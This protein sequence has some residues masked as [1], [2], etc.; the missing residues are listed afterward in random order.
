MVRPGD[1]VAFSLSPQRNMA[2]VFITLL[3][4]LCKYRYSFNDQ[5]PSI[6]YISA[7]GC[8]TDSEL[9]DFK[10]AFVKELTT[11]D[12]F[13]G[14]KLDGECDILVIDSI[15]MISWLCTDENELKIYQEKINDLTR[16][17]TTFGMIAFY[18]IAPNTTI[19]LNPRVK[20]YT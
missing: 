19:P 3:S 6:G 16:V 20:I 17:I 8:L 5:P 13:L 9:R 7:L 2:S 1:S 11:V 4:A 18:G 10:L 15:D 12:E 14:L